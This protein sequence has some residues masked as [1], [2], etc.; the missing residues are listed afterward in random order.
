MVRW[1]LSAQAALLVGVGAR[2]WY[3]FLDDSFWRDESMLL[4]NVSQK[5]F[6]ALMGPLDYAQSAPIPIL[7]LYRLLYLSGAGGE[8]PIRAV[9]LAASILALFLFYYLARRMISDRQAV[10]FATWLVALS[11]GAILF[12]AQAKPYALDMLVAACLLWLAIPVLTFQDNPPSL[13]RLLWAA[14]LAPWVSYPALFIL[15]GLSIALLLRCRSFGSPPPAK[16]LVAIAS[17]WSVMA[18]VILFNLRA[19]R[20]AST[21]SYTWDSFN[22]YKYWWLW[23]FCQV[24]YAYLGPKEISM[25]DRSYPHGYHMNPFALGVAGLVTLGLWESRKRWGW[26]WTLALASPLGL[27]LAA[28]SFKLYLPYGRLFLF[29]VPCLSLLAGHGAA[30]LYQSV[31]WR[32]LTNM[33]LVFIILSCGIA[34]LR[35]F[36]APVGGM[37]EALDY[38]AI[39]QHPGDLV[40]FDAYAAPTIAYYRLIGRLSAVNLKYGLDPEGF[41][42]GKRSYSREESLS[43]MPPGKGIWLVAETMDYIRGP[44]TTVAPSVSVVEKELNASRAPMSAYITD[45]VQVREFSPAF[46]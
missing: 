6:A 23:I 22:D 26:P 19:S 12:A 20:E 29:A 46:K 42:E 17:S 10:S 2:F 14:A 33:L 21:L 13:S 34:S 18:L 27:A 25:A 24:F 43:L 16:G 7:W 37:R 36:G 31:R 8:L 1:V 35:S 3:Y 4:L 39:N 11:P 41:L 9:S 32:L 28:I 45:R 44:V 5:T 38:I 15:G 30:W 40:F